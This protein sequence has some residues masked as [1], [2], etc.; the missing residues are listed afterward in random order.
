MTG[1]VHYGRALTIRS[2]KVLMCSSHNW[3]DKFKRLPMFGAPNRLLYEIEL[4]WNLKLVM[5]PAAS[6]ACDEQYYDRIRPVI[7]ITFS[8]SVRRVENTR[9]LGAY[10]INMFF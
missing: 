1:E 9:L 8:S 6:V 7:R 4:T 2:Y 3:C 10:G 5:L